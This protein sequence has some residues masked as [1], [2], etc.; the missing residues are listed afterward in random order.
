MTTHFGPLLSG[1]IPTII[2]VGLLVR[3][4][5]RGSITR[6]AW[7]ESRTLKMH[8]RQ[9]AT[10]SSY[11]GSTPTASRHSGNA[12]ASDL[13]APKFAPHAKADAWRSGYE[14][15]LADRQSK[16]PRTNHEPYLRG[17]ND[18]RTRLTK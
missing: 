16:P 12:P 2:L 3:W 10:A 9:R 6:Q 13:A 18:G 4:L 15:A 17:Y 1:S 11:G 7:R 8:D 14:D 5:W